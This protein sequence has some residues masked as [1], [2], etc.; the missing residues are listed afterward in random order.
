M[1]RHISTAAV[2]KEISI[3]TGQAFRKSNRILNGMV[4]VCLRRE[5]SRRASYVDIRVSDED[6]EKIQEY[7]LCH[8]DQGLQHEIR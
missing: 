3:I 5:N 1:Q 6:Q 8:S 2:N 4:G 7:F